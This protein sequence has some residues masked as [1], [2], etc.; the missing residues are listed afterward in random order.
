VFV[1]EAK[2]IAEGFEFGRSSNQALV[3]STS[4]AHETKDCISLEIS[5]YKS[6]AKLTK[7]A[8][9]ESPIKGLFRR[10]L[11]VGFPRIMHGGQSVDRNFVSRRWPTVVLKEILRN[12]DAGTLYKFGELCVE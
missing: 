11:E 10:I 1:I 5:W 12:V 8:I 4:R 6:W 2:L 3:D 9:P 7:D